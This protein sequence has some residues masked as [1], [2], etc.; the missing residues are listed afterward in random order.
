MAPERIV[1]T[2][3]EVSYEEKWVALEGVITDENYI[4]AIKNKF[5][6]GSGKFSKYAVAV[7]NLAELNLNWCG[8]DTFVQND[9]VVVD[10]GVYDNPDVFFEQH[11]QKW[12]KLKNFAYVH[13]GRKVMTR[14]VD[15]IRNRK[16]EMKNGIGS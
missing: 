13:Y 12:S 9:A 11:K 2:W 3:V 8:K 10:Y 16:R 6:N 14:N 5:K 4:T 7:P 1:H 15:R